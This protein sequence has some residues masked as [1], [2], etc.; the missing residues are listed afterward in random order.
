MSQTDVERLAA[1]EDSVDAASDRVEAGVLE[2]AEVT[3]TLRAP[4]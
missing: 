4:C 3:L 2:V 1:V